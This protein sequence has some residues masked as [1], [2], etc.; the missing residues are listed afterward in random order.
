VRQGRSD[1]PDGQGAHADHCRDVD[2]L[3]TQEPTSL[4]NTPRASKVRRQGKKHGCLK[5]AERRPY[6][7]RDDTEQGECLHTDERSEQQPLEL[8]EHRIRSVNRDQG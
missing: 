1:E 7:R 4:G 3:T 8:Q 5:H 2:P 6:E